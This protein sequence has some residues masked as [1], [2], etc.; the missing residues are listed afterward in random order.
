M[1]RRCRDTPTRLGRARDGGFGR[2]EQQKRPV[3]LTRGKAQALAFLEIERLR[4][5]ADDDP[6][7]TRA[8]GLFDRPE[9][10]HV[11]LG[12]DERKP[13]WIEAER[14]EPMAMKPA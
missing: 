1:G 6:S 11:F 14:L 10:V 12:L 8:Q 5:E 13:P 9:G 3:R 7:G 2:S 4:N